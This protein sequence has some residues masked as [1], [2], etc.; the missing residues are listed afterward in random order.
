MIS[1]RKQLKNLR[2]ESAPNKSFKKDLW[3]ELDSAW[4]E[5]YPSARISWTRIAA[6][7]VAVLVL[8]A[9]TSTGVYAYSSPEVT[10][11]SALYPVKQGM[12]SVE[13]N[14]YR[15]PEAQARFHARL[16][17]RR[18]AEAEVMLRRGTITREKLEGIANEF[19]ITVEQ[20]QAAKTDPAARAEVRE[21]I[22]EQLEMHDVRYRFLL[23]QSLMDGDLGVGDGSIRN[24][25]QELRVQVNDSG[26]E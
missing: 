26:T 3:R 21:Q 6:I 10:E 4:A 5:E 18:I 19:G 12:E 1:L 11:D 22:I 23:R 7:P 16:V 14:F 24:A 20:L 2:K 25:L 15:S 8:F 9:F 13:S 17:R